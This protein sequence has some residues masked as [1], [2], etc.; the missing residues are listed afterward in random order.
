MTLTDP[1]HKVE[2]G[3]RKRI[4][5]RVIQ[6]GGCGMCA[7]RDRGQDAWDRGFCSVRNRTFPFCLHDKGEPSFQLDEARL[8][9][10]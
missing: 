10:G 1:E 7:N 5:A 2:R 6:C 3:V 9:D 8:K 4:V